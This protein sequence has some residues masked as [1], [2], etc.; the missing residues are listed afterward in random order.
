MNMVYSDYYDVA[1]EFVVNRPESYAALV[2][3]FLMDKDGPESEEK[4]GAYYRNIVS[5]K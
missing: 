3:A 2:K 5:K 4:L 1:T